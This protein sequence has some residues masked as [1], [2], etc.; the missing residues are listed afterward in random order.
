MGQPWLIQQLIAE[1]RQEAFVAPSLAARAAI[2]LEHVQG[3]IMLL[4]SEKFALLQARNFAKY[5][6]R[7]LPQK[8]AF[9]LAMQCCETLQEMSAICTRYFE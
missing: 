8:A 1:M 2:Y 5:Y 9:V 4:G 6:A 7:E 3:L